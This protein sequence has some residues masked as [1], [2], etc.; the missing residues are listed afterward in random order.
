MRKKS[1]IPTILVVF[2]LLIGV[3]AG[4]FFLNTKQVFKIG[5]SGSAQ[6]KDVKISNISDNSATVSWTTDSQTSGFLVWG[7]S[8]GAL[9][10]VGQENAN[11][12]KLITHSISLSGLKPGTDYFFKINSQG[13]SFDNNGV[14]WEFTTGSTLGAS[15]TSLFVSGSVIDTAGSPVNHA[16]V[17]ISINDY[18]ASTVSSDKGNFV[19]QLGS[20][21]TSDLQNYAQ[22][23]PS[24]TLLTISVSGGVGGSASAQVFPQSAD[25]I[26]PMMLG[27]TYDFRNQTPSSNTG[28]PNANLS[29]PSTASRESKI[30]V[31]SPAPSSAPKSVVLESLTE[32]E[33]VTSSQ[34]E[35]FGKGPPGETVT[36]EVHS[37]NPITGN[38]T[39]PEDGSWSFTVPTGL[40]PGAHSI[41]I[42]WKD[43]TGITRSLTR[44]FIVQASDGPAFEATPSQTLAPGATPVATPEATP[45]V[46]PEATFTPEPVPT[47]SEAPVP[48]TG[49]L[50]PTLLFSMLGVLITVFS[51]FVW[52]TAET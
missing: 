32:G 49:N 9:S 42:T 1:K 24:S 29:L 11:D 40:S 34:P 44:N 52:K 10:K 30:N 15:P 46:T 37:Q 31:G 18:L 41:T 50:T 20:I 38:V 47:P 14:P 2:I 33:T 13:N 7:E 8:E 4:V 19:Y 27:Q 43:T 51:V 39:V 17:Y 25:P 12:E 28:I 45:T 35:F 3:F 16:L 22:I 26:P 5:A 23:D 6:P 21:R 36:I 48:I